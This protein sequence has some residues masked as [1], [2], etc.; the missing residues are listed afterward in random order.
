[1]HAGIGLSSLLAANPVYFGEP[2]FITAEGSVNWVVIGLC[3]LCL[4]APL[5]RV[6]N[7]SDAALLAGTLVWLTF[8]KLNFFVVGSGFIL[9]GLM[10]T[11]DHRRTGRTEVP[12][13]A[14]RILFCCCRWCLSF[15]FILT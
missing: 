10:G 5:S 15:H 1:M 7:V 3:C 12:G 9:L 11:P 2:P 8:Y 6:K 14:G 13:L 4:L